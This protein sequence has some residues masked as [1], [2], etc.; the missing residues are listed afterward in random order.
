M[1]NHLVEMLNK[2]II[3]ILLFHYYYYYYYYYCYYLLPTPKCFDEAMQT[4]KK[5]SIAFANISR[6][7]ARI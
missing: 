7:L 5:C 4:G 1:K 2:A 6:E 3:I